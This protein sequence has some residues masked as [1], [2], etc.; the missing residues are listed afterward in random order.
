[1]FSPLS[2]CVA[3]IKCAA[4]PPMCFLNIGGLQ[5]RKLNNRTLKEK[6]AKG[7]DLG[8]YRLTNIWA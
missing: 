7:Y 5:S 6:G 4:M 1:M 3:D 8:R 2:K